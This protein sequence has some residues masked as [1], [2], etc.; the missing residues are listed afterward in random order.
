MGPVLKSVGKILR[1]NTRFSDV[2]GRYGGEEFSIIFPNTSPDKAVLALE[3]LRKIVERYDFDGVKIT[4][5]F[6]C[7]SFPKVGIR[8]PEDLLAKADEALYV[9]KCKGKNRVVSL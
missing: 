6:G 9:A 2:V 4:M 7:S 1:E 5:S 3:K 8:T